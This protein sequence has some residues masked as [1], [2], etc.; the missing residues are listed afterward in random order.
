MSHSVHELDLPLA[1]RPD[2]T[3]SEH[4]PVGMATDRRRGITQFT[5]HIPD[6]NARSTTATASSTDSTAGKSGKSASRWSTV[7]FKIY[8]LVFAVVV[9]LM[10]WIP[11]R[12]SQGEYSAFNLSLA[13]IVADTC[14]A[15]LT[16]SHP[17]YHK[18]AYRLSNGWI[19]GRKVVCGVENSH[20]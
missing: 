8:G 2:Q 18:Y 5:V 17:N 1:H 12:L 7:E 14:L 20:L 9:P 15:F 6:A 16:E 3:A 13:F 19:P 10:V 11:I 4:E